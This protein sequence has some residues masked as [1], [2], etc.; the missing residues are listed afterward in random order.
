MFSPFI[1]QMHFFWARFWPSSQFTTVLRRKIYSCPI[2]GWHEYPRYWRCRAYRSKRLPPIKR[3]YKSSRRLK[4][5]MSE[6]VIMRCLMTRWTWRDILDKL[7]MHTVV[8]HPYFSS[9]L[10]SQTHAP[11][12][13]LLPLIHYCLP[14]PSGLHPTLPE[15]QERRVSPMRVKVFTQHLV[16]STHQG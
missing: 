9:Y 14:F 12:S 10:T 7:P 6:I 15:T 2:V 1:F 4:N 3:C 8:S 5:S 11:L 16:E 13:L